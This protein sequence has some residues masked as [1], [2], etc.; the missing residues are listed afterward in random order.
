MAGNLINIGNPGLNFGAI[1]VSYGPKGMTSHYTVTCPTIGP[2]IAYFNYIVQYGATGEFFGCDNGLDGVTSAEDKHLEVSVPGLVNNLSEFLNELFFD[3]WELMTNEAS[4]TIMA[5]PLIVG[6]ATGGGWMTANDKD[7]LS[8]LITSGGTVS[9]AVSAANTNVPD[10]KPHSTPSDA[11]TKQ[12]ILE[13]LKGQVEYA[14]PSYVLR[15][16]SYCSAGQYY[17]SR[18]QHVMQIYTPAQLLTEVGS[19][20]VYNLPPRLYSKIASIPFQYAP[21]I[22]APYYTFGWLKK[23]TREP[24]L[25]NFVVEINTEYELNLWSNLRYQRHP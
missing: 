13:I 3:V 24:V 21:A 2:L 20:W 9:E 25:S 10:N 12:L 11:R 19:G 17:N 15:H 18:I 6:T 8:V 7:V 5:N 22:E 23:I 16:T 1:R 4:D 14:K